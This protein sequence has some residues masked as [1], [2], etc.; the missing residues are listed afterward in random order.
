MDP[1]RPDSSPTSLPKNTK[2]FPAEVKEEM[3]K[4]GRRTSRCSSELPGNCIRDT[5]RLWTPRGPSKK[6]KH[7]GCGELA[8][9]IRRRSKRG[10]AGKL[11]DR[12]QPFGRRECGR[13]GGGVGLGAV[14]SFMAERW[15]VMR[16]SARIPELILVGIMDSERFTAES[17]KQEGSQSLIRRSR[18]PL[19]D[20]PGNLIIHSCSL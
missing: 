9:V 18:S 7:S 13:G 14:V 16:T 17:R 4:A 3:K 12:K 1:H 19:L 10:Q 6:K 5:P 2:G 8:S 11:V 20:Q 15:N